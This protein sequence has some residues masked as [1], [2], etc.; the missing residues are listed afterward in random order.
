[1]ISMLRSGQCLQDNTEPSLVNGSDYTCTQ[2]GGA[3]WTSLR[4]TDHYSTTYLRCVAR[5]GTICTI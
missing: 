1:M 3:F 2:L 5:F 4:I